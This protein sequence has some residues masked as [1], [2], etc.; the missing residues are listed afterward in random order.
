[1]G[2]VV[3]DKHVKFHDPGL[4]RSREI[5][6]EALGCGIFYCF[7]FNFRAEVDND[8]VS[9]RAVENVGMD[10][11]KEFGDSSQTVSEIFEELLSCR[12]NERTFSKTIPIARNASKNRW[13]SNENW[14][15]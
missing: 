1:M 15:D 3:L 5:P 4:N 10:V 2:P 9:G 7:P 14:Q 8:V 11:P 13:H 12:T 6:P